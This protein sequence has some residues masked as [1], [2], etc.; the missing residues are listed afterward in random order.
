M[1]VIGASLPRRDSESKV[2]G[3]LRF[4]ADVPVVGLLHARLVLAHEAHA[5]ISGIDTEAA[6]ATPG[7]VA[8]LTAGDLPLVGTGP[9]RL[10]EPLAREE[11][12]YAG[13]PVALVV[14]ESE[15]QAEDGAQLVEVEL[16]PLPPVLDLE[17]AARPGAPRARVIS[18]AGGADSDLGDAHASVSA[19]GI[20]DEELSENVLDTARLEHGDVT[21]EL[22]A[23]H[24]VVRGRF[25]TPWMYQGYIEPQTATAWLEPDGELVVHTSTQAAFAT[26]DALAKLFGLPVDRIRVRGAPPGGAFGGKMMIIEPVVAAA[27][28]VLHRPVRLAMTRSE[29]LAASNPAGA[30]VLYLELGADADGQLTGVRS[31]AFVDR[32]ATD[33]FGVETIAAMLASGPYRWR[34]HELTALGI[35]TNRMTFGAYRAPAAPPAAFA[36]ESLLDELA[37]Q[38]GLD[39]L[40]LRLRNVAGEGDPAPSGQPFPVFGAR[41]CLE[42]VGEHPLWARRADLP[43]GEGIGLAIGWWPG[44]YEPASAACRLDADGHLTIITGAA[45]LT[46]VETTFAAIAADA[47]GVDPSRV[48]VVN[49]DTSTAPYAGVSGGSKVTYTVG[50][51]VERA[52]IEARDR[53]LEVAAEELEIGPD[54]LEIVDG[55]VRPKG[56]PAKALAIDE[57]APKILSFGSRHLP[58]EGHGRS[59]QPQAPQAAAHLSHVRVDPDT[60]A[61]TVLAHVTAQD[62][63]RALNPALVEGQM[64]GGATQG[65]GWAL[66]EE[67][68]HDDH[69]QLVTGTFV[70]YALPTASLVPLIDTEI[71]EVPAPEGPYGAKGVGEAPV[72]GV[73]GAVANAI[74]AATGGVRMRRLP[75]TPERVWRAMTESGR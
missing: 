22:A 43:A 61:V 11:V 50:R 51:A 18:R 47:F 28:L 48:R 42:R 6:R 37:Q 44:G 75:M 27:A 30:E 21:A 32:G 3:T 56:V 52:A 46:G 20:V 8:V 62:V 29:D 71:V 36:V 16:E 23:S 60:G 39:P 59:A 9:G 24:V 10:N 34:A 55:A 49:A 33:E 67:I 74:A 5:T 15:A 13:Q 12:V 35:A 58:V 17:A 7:V 68:A 31:R 57:L 65:L 53:L 69:G 64:R 2:R 1:A 70:D 14:A 26:R 66:L 63:G 54:D 41:Q 25:T 38:L 72:V 45:D 4:A 73:P 40:R 19:G